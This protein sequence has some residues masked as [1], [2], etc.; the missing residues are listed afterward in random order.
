MDGNQVTK[1]QV[2][3]FETGQPGRISLEQRSAP[4][5][6]LTSEVVLQKNSLDVHGVKLVLG[7]STLAFSGRLNNFKDPRYDVKAETDLA[8]GSL[9]QLAGVPQKIDGTVHASL[10]A[11]GPI[12][13]PKPRTSSIWNR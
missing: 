5:Q 13:R 4:V 6:S 8:L 9:T 3:R 11:T 7:D 1:E 10:T 12:T 2:I